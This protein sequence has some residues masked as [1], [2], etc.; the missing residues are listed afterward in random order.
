MSGVYSV[1]ELNVGI[2]CICMPTFRRFLAHFV[3]NCFAS[4]QTDSNLKN[5]EDETPNARAST[6]K[7]GRSGRKRST[8][9]GSL[10]NTTIMKTIDT[11][12]T[13]LNKDDDE[14]QL[15]ELQRNGELQKNGKSVNGSEHGSTE[16][17]D[18]TQ[19]PT[20]FYHPQ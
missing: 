8:M 3:P 15:V 4:S 14:V 19:K 5:Y 16:V 6:K 11:R 2:I 17:H 12:V 13:S 9:D 10:F 18:S 1:L 20:S 7:S